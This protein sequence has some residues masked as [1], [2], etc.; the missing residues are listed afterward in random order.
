MQSRLLQSQGLAIN[1]V[2]ILIQKNSSS[3]GI[4]RRSKEYSRRDGSSTSERPRV[5]GGRSAVIAVIRAMGWS[6]TGP[7]LDISHPL[8]AFFFPTL[9]ST[10]YTGQYRCWFHQTLVHTPKEIYLDKI[11]SII[12]HQVTPLASF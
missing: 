3:R 5:Y 6:V 2:A 11:V 4:Q 8:A 10:I 7:L 12:D 9:S 1:K